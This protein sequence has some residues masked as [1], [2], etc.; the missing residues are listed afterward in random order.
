MVNG[1]PLFSS[2]DFI[3]IFVLPT[4]SECLDKSF[5]DISNSDSIVKKIYIDLSL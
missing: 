2:L 1:D 5:E 3:K 4:M